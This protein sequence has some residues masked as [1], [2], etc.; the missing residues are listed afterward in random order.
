MIPGSTFEMAFFFVFSKGHRVPFD[1]FTEELA[2]NITWR[3][4]L[5]WHY[6]GDPNV[7]VQVEGGA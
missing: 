1:V 4:T 6:F 2:K 7:L 5:V 3:E